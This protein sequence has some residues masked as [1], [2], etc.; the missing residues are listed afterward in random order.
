MRIFFFLPILLSLLLSPL[1]QAQALTISTPTEMEQAS[2]RIYVAGLLIGKVW[3]WWE[4]DAHYYKITTSIKTSGVALIFNKQ[5]RMAEL[6]G[7]RD[8]AL[9]TPIHYHASVKYPHKQ[10]SVDI[11]YENGEM[12]DVVTQPPEENAMDAGQQQ[13][14]LD[15]L[16]G[17]LQ[18]L[19]F[20]R[21]PDAMEQLFAAP[22]FDGKRLFRGYALPSLETL[23]ECPLPCQAYALYRKPLVG[24]DTDELDAF[25]RRPEPP[26]ILLHNP[27]TSHFPQSLIVRTQLGT[28]Q[29]IRDKD[30]R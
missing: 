9:F 23:E 26:L 19:V 6:A 15:P 29:V 10:K 2:Y 3:V 21:A 4:A 8:G 18:L 5:K 16:S 25:A 12:R 13:G 11:S 28:V 24:Y 1:S 14:A 17:F 22:V 7:K 27:V 20:M 30:T